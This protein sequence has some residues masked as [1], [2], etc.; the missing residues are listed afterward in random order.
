[1]YPQL[2]HHDHTGISRSHPMDLLMKTKHQAQD[3]AGLKNDLGPEDSDIAPHPP[4]PPPPN[5]H[6]YNA[7][8][9]IFVLLCYED[10]NQIHLMAPT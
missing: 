6:N 7:D 9:I 4:P 1:M 10:I 3:R 5:T 8:D 2:H